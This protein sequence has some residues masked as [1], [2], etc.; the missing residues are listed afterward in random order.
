[1]RLANF[2]L[3]TYF[4]QNLSVGK[5]KIAIMLLLSNFTY[6]IILISEV[7]VIPNVYCLKYV[8]SGKC[9]KGIDKVSGC[10]EV[11]PF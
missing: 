9:A 1:M 10:V 3:E 2:V 6:S 11:L 8:S 4:E 5:L 7:I